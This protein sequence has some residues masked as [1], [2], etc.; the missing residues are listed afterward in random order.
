MAK[1][2]QISPKH[3]NVMD[4]TVEQ[5]ARVYAK[6]VMDA[7]AKSKSAEGS[8]QELKSLVADVLNRFPKLEQVFKSSLVSA[9]QKEELLGRVFGKAVSV[10]VLNFLK[11]L[12]RHGRLEILRSIVRETEKLHTER[13]GLANIQVRVAAKLDDSLLKDLE[14][15]LKKMLGKEP[16]LDVMVDPSLIA[17]IVVRV[18][19]RVYDGSVYTQLEHARQSMIERATEQIETA[20]DKFLSAG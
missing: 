16:N 12:A 4:V 5:L 18:G 3:E 9:E 13:S 19:D 20:P 6:A 11:V 2:E 10:Q 15:R 14:A 17:G 8:V 1:P 7:A